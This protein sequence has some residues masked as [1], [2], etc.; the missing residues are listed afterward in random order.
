MRTGLNPNLLQKRCEI[1]HA[2]LFI[3]VTG[4]PLRYVVEPLSLELHIENENSKLGVR[5]RLLDHDRHGGGCGLSLSK[6]DIYHLAVAV[7]A[8][9][10]LT[11]HI[12]DVVTQHSNVPT[13]RLRDETASRRPHSVPHPCPRGAGPREE[14]A[15]DISPS[16][17]HARPLARLLFQ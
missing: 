16:V 9:I 4:T 11:K 10:A 5:L 8:S 7:R 6:A 13:E 3:G 12:S 2:A 15:R 14:A 1:H 17:P